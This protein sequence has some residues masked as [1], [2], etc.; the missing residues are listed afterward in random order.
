MS[1]QAARTV[2]QRLRKLIE[3]VREISRDCQGVAYDDS[4]GA[5][6]EQAKPHIDKWPEHGTSGGK[7]ANVT[8]NLYNSPTF[9]G[10]WFE[11][12][13]K[14]ESCRF[15]GSWWDMICFARNVLASEN[16]RLA[17]PEFYRPE[18]SNDNYTGP[19]PYTFGDEER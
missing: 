14:D 7:R 1:E 19:K 18:W 11:G 2:G 10:D 15:E 5:M 17:A 12:Y 9:L 4:I 6:S 16:T 3:D 13:G 8:A